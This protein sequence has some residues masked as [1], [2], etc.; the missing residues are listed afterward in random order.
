MKRVTLMLCLAALWPISNS[1][2]APIVFD[3]NDGTFV[4]LPAVG[5]QSVDYT[6]VYQSP[7]FDIDDVTIGAAETF[8]IDFEFNSGVGNQ[9]IRLTDLGNGLPNEGVI[10]DVQGTGSSQVNPI[11]RLTGASGSYRQDTSTNIQVN[12]ETVLS[13]AGASELFD[14]GIRIGEFNDSFPNDPARFL[15]VALDVTQFSILFRDL[16]LEV[17]NGGAN[18]ITVTSLRFQAIANEVEIVSVPEPA[19]LALIGLGL[20]CI[21]Y[22]RRK[23]VN[24]G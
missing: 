6:G 1:L 14:D 15:N 22:G 21:G 9:F 13:Y 20:A 17:F 5:S 10:F 23:R 7:T 4:T 8:S 16:H 3:L 24:T 2:A 18:P 11:V 19:S 12:D